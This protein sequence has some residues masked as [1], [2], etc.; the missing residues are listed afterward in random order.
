MLGFI[1]K[2]YSLY[3]I[4]SLYWCKLG[5]IIKEYSLYIGVRRFGKVYNQGILSLYWCETFWEAQSKA[6]PN[7]QGILSHWC[8]TFWETESSKK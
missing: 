5:F 7:H 4:L 6:K 3:G 2:E 1:I 8:E